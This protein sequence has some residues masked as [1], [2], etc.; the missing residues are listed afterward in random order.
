MTFFLSIISKPKGEYLQICKTVYNKETKSSY[1]KNYKV[2]GYVHDLK[3]IY[4]DPVSYF[5]D[6]VKNLNLKEKEEKALKVTNQPIT[7]N[8]GY[9]LIKAMLNTLGVKKE[10]DL[11]GQ[12]YKFGNS[13]SSFVEAM[14]YCQ[15]IKPSSNKKF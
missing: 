2:L 7:Q 9:F 3:S 11:M 8:I 1:N 10:L 6:V 13:I 4:D 12:C 5:N 15:I 14:I